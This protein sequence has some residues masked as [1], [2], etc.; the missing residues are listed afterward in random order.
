[1]VEFKIQGGKQKPKNIGT[2]EYAKLCFV[3][4]L[5]KP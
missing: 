2:G 3:F 1:M 4:N 5:F